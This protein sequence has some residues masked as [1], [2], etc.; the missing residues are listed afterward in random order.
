M[1]VYMYMYMIVIMNH[2]PS[3]SPTV[4]LGLDRTPDVRSEFGRG[5][6]EGTSR[7]RTLC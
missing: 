2:R 7:E 5:I 4:T 6:M 3:L 1:C